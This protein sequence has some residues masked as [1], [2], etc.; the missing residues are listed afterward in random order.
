M[1]IDCLGMKDGNEIDV[2]LTHQCNAAIITKNT[3]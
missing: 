3:I 2:L 1:S